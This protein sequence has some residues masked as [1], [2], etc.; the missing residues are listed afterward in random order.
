MPANRGAPAL[1][2]PAC[3]LSWGELCPMLPQA[4]PRTGGR[5]IGPHKNARKA[6]VF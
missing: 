4:L 6:G 5:S 2:E 3:A 1:G